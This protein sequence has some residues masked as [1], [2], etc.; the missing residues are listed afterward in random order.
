MVYQMMMAVI[1]RK[2]KLIFI[3]WASQT[4]SELNIVL[5]YYLCTLII[6]PMSPRIL[7][8]LTNCENI[9]CCINQNRVDDML[10]PSVAVILILIYC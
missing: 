7:I 4:P 5:A 2:Y 3:S 10:S 6:M 8:D 1:F 9:V